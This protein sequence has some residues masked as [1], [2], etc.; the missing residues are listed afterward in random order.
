MAHK[1][2]R[3]GI[4]INTYSPHWNP[5]DNKI[6]GGLR[7]IWSVDGGSKYDK[8]SPWSTDVPKLNQASK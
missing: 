5:V 4:Q 1:L 2:K 6:F 7:T 3:N 8:Q